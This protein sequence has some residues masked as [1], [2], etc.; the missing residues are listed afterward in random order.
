MP[1]SSQP[2]VPRPAGGRALALYVVGWVVTGALVAV[3]AVTLLRGDGDENVTLPP[4]RQTELT[5]AARRA[6]CQLRSGRGSPGSEPV[7]EG[8]PAS[9]ARAGF[10]D[11]EP[12]RPSLVGALRR[13]L[14][15]ISY[16]PPLPEEREEQLRALQRAVPEGTV[17]VPNERMRY[18]VAVTAWRRLLGCPRFEGITVD[19]MRLFRGRYI[20]SGPESPR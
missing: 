4:V 19:A 9:P 7:V 16:R 11:R 20:G 2:R 13:G 5:E 14:I 6:G 3:A 17:V 18:V 1:D 8:G 15:I 10:Y 12:P